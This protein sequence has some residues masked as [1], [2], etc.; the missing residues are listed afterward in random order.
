MLQILA[1][2]GIVLTV[3]VAVLFLTP[4][5]GRVVASVG[6]SRAAGD[7]GVELSIESTRGSLARGITFEGVK[8][9]TEDGTRLLE[10]DGLGV[11]LGA[12]SLRSK[13]VELKSLRIDG[14]ELLFVSD[15]E[16]ALIG[17]SGLR[18]R[19]TEDA[20]SDSAEA[21]AWEISLDLALADVTVI[22][23]SAASGLDLVVGPSSGTASGTVKEF[24]AVL[25]GAVSIDTRALRAPIKGGFDG[26]VRFA[27]GES[28]ELAPLTLHTNVG[29][30]LVK[31]TVWLRDPGRPV[32]PAES[33]AGA[34]QAEDSPDR[35]TGASADLVIESTH[36]LPQLAA[37]LPEAVSQ[38]FRDATG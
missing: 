36:G 1:A 33:R 30:A 24:D 14:G 35:R 7:S 26:S 6:W 15:A 32:R 10:T 8:L 13:R 16:G 19:R 2:I 27:A 5:G 4:F 29:E 12:I 34:L 25:A 22:V 38:D 37:L 23:R 17:W 21:G 18:R 20:L 9:T 11:R 31:G 28:V 3:L